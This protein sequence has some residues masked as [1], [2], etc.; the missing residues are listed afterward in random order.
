[1]T[2]LRY[3]AALLFILLFTHILSAQPAAW[4]VVNGQ[5]PDDNNRRPGIQNTGVNMVVSGVTVY[6]PPDDCVNPARPTYK[7]FKKLQSALYALQQGFLSDR[8]IVV[9]TNGPILGYDPAVPPGVSSN[10]DVRNPV[11]IVAGPS[12]TPVIRGG[13]N[14]V[15][16]SSLGVSLEGFEITGGSGDGISVYPT[17]GMT[18]SRSLTLVDLFIHHNTQSGVSINGRVDLTIMKRNNRKVRIEDH[19]AYGVYVDGRGL[20]SITDTEIRRSQYD[21]IRLTGMGLTL[22]N[23]IIDSSGYRGLGMRRTQHVAI[24]YCE[25][26]NNQRGGVTIDSTGQNIARLTSN[27][28]TGNLQQAVWLKKAGAHFIQDTIRNTKGYG[29]YAERSTPITFENCLVDSSDSTGIRAVD[30]SWVDVQRTKVSRSGVYGISAHRSR[31]TMTRSEVFLSRGIGVYLIGGDLSMKDSCIVDTSG[32]QGVELVTNATGLIERSTIKRNAGGIYIRNCPGRLAIRNN[33]ILNNRTTSQGGGILVWQNSK[34]QIMG[35]EIRGNEAN[36]IG[37]GISIFEAAATIGSAA[38]GDS[39]TIVENETKNGIGGGIAVSNASGDIR[40]EHNDISRNRATSSNPQTGRGGGVAI[41]NTRNVTIRFMANTVD[42]NRVKGMGGGFYA[43]EVRRCTFN[44]GEAG[45]NANYFRWN[46]ADS[47]DSLGTNAAMRLGGGLLFSNSDSIFVT[48]NHIYGNRGTG[49]YLADGG[50]HTITQNRIGWDPSNNPAPDSGDGIS[51]VGS[52]ENFIGSGNRIGNNAGNGISVGRNGRRN[53]IAKN[54]ITANRLLGIHLWSGGNTMVEAPILTEVSRGRVRGWVPAA[55]GSSVEVYEDPDGEGETYKGNM[56]LATDSTFQF[57]GPFANDGLNVTATVTTPDGNTSEFGNAVLDIV[58]DRPANRTI[59][60]ADPAAVFLEIGLWGE[61]DGAMG[62]TGYN[63]G[64]VRNDPGTAA[65]AWNNYADRDPNRFYVRVRDS[66]GNADAGIIDTVLAV[67]E[68]RDS[69]GNVDDDPTEIQLLETG[70]NTGIF[71]SASQLL[72][73]PD[74]SFETYTDTDGNGAYTA[75]E[76]FVDRDGNGAYSTDNPDDHFQVH[77]GMRGPIPDDRRNDRTHRASVDDSVRVWYAPFRRLPSPSRKVPV[78]NRAPESRHNLTVQIYVFNEPWRDVGYDHDGNPA[79]PNV[80]AGD[81]RFNY[82]DS[83]GNGRH[84]AGERCEPFIDI[85]TGAAAFNTVGAYGPIW[86]T[87]QIDRTMVFARSYLSVSRVRII[88]LPRLIVN[89]VGTL[90]RNVTGFFDDYPDDATNA[91]LSRDESIIQT[92]FRSAVDTI[93]DDGNDIID[94]YFV[95]PLTPAGGAFA[96]AVIP[97]LTA[98]HGRPMN[99]I[100]QAHIGLNTSTRNVPFVPAHE[101]MHHL[102]NQ[103]DPH[104]PVYIHFPMDGAFAGEG[105][106]WTSKRRITSATNNRAQT[107]P[108]AAG[109]GNNLLR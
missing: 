51:V 8:K 103:N 31:V 36:G 52:N 25:F 109:Q 91:T 3:A 97:R 38:P 29:F 80:G 61:D 44:I 57:P 55:V 21:G 16:V 22:E 81:N 92:H 53:R 105:T 77:D 96:S 79:T 63:G 49:I 27:I 4:I 89:P 26:T 40:I 20:C 71:A 30:S 95:A 85:S 11:E 66:R 62:L 24:R 73:A 108:R 42:S 74:L 39:N 67:I 90:F 33:R 64:A 99:R 7:Q 65:N 68:T 19:G 59:E 2:L 76:A 87:E 54:I 47:T 34:P 35:N 23:T 78:F 69:S 10:I 46:S 17:T 84:T 101:I 48:G 83:D 32:N 107:T 41:H 60:M 88:E 98:L 102:T 82:T 58:L 70:V 9:A 43:L 86:T 100:N 72:V 6:D 14:V 12:T 94:L 15:T 5:G 1:M 28:F 106:R 104:T 50:K 18:T 13:T 37:G 45:T 56:A 75:G 93:A